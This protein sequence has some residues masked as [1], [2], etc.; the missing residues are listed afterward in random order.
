MS[1]YSITSF[2]IIIGNFGF[3]LIVATFLFPI[4]EFWSFKLSSISYVSLRKCFN[5]FVSISDKP[6]NI[7]ECIC[8]DNKI[9]LREKSNKKKSNG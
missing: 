4:C 8:P 3:N 6:L 2:E 7:G 9:H 1:L 5:S